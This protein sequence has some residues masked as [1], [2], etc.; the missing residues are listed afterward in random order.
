[1]S[2]IRHA[3]LV[4]HVD[5]LIRRS[6]CILPARLLT[7]LRIDTLVFLARHKVCSSDTLQ[8]WFSMVTNGGT[9]LLNKGFYMLVQERV[10]FYGRSLLASAT[11]TKYMKTGHCEHSD[12]GCLRRETFELDTYDGVHEYVDD[13]VSFYNFRRNT[14]ACFGC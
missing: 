11:T 9:A 10:Y 5:V 2:R 8:T 6:R 12:D 1:M 13:V 7:G 14:L 4:P 3:A